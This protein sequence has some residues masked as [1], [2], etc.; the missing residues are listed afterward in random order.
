MKNPIKP[1][2]KTEIIPI[3]TLLLMVSGAYY[4]YSRFPEQVPIHWN[5]AGEVD[6]WGSRLMGAW[7]IP[8]I[9]AVLYLMFLI[10]PFFDP[11][12]DRYVQFKKVYHIFKNVFIAFM[13]FIYFITGFNVLGYNVPIGLWV[14]LMVGVLFVIIGNY[15]GK[16]KRNW[17]FGIKTPWSLSSEE[18]WNKTH[19]FGGKAFILGGLILLVTPFTP[20]L[21]QLW[22]FTLSLGIILLGTIGYSFYLF[23]K[24]NKK[25]DRNNN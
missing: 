2:L 3:L 13:A 17:F 18:N 6:R 9:T 4:F 19:R 21:C 25:D 16:V 10:I 22:L 8:V 15:L 5:F 7:G 14:P 23:L 11:H 20:L 24:E 12:Q 1:K